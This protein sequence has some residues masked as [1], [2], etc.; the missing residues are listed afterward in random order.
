[1]QNISR[2]YQTLLNMFEYLLIC[3]EKDKSIDIK[4]IH[5][6]VDCMYKVCLELSI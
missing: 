4:D 2:K 6:F 1:M 5:Q 3:L